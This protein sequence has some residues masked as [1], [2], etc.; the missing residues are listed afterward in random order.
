MQS[1][2]CGMTRRAPGHR[3]KLGNMI[4][5]GS[6]S[7]HP[8]RTTD[9]RIQGARVL[10]CLATQLGILAFLAMAAC[11]PSGR[12]PATSTGSVG[13]SPV[14]FDAG[15]VHIETAR[16]TLRLQ[17]EVAERPDQRTQGLMERQQLAAD[18]GMIFLFDTRQDSS[19]G[20][21]M[22]RTRIPLDIA[23]LNERGEIV[24]ILGMEPCGSPNPATC[25]RYSPGVD[26]HAALEVNRGYF[27]QH[28]VRPGDR[29]ALVR[30][31]GSNWP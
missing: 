25:R 23:F 31:G 14:S 8:A 28:G 24:A 7:G 27:D 10:R 6:G 9:R 18:A 1:G 3:R 21:W 13:A 15:L 19:G 17:V 16:D 20:F 26:Y 11:D 22:F 29:V 30:G 5:T 4:R 12:D 2:R